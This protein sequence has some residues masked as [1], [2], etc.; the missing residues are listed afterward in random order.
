ML[1]TWAGNR[2]FSAGPVHTP[3]TMAELQEV[4]AA[5]AHIRALGTRHCFNDIA[6]GPG[7]LVSL[8]D[9]DVPVELDEEART[10]TVGGGVRYGEL[11]KVLHERGWALHNLASLGHIS[12]AGA[13]A[14]A[15]H[16]SG[17][18]SQNL[19]AGVVALDLVGPDGELR[20][21]AR[22]DANFAGSVVSLGALGVAARVTLQVEP[23]YDVAQD[24]HV[25]LP[26]DAALANFDE[27]TSSADSVS[28]FTDWAGDDVLQVWRKSRVPAGTTHVS[29]TELFGA[30]PAES[31]RHMIA[32]IDP[33]HTTQQ[34]GVVGPWHERIPHFRLEFTPSNGAEL[35][36]EYLVP[37]PHAV[38][39]IQAMRGLAPVVSPLLQVAEVRTMAG[40][41]LWLSG[42]YGGDTVAL[43][44]TW[45][46]RQ[47]EVEAVLPVIE[48]ALAPFRARPHWGKLFA[49]RDRD[50]ARLYPHWDDFR[51]LVARTDPDGV[52][53]NDYLARHGLVG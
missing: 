51:A 32:G 49:D 16:G 23:T 22:G 21:V 19:S 27:L 33:V 35:Q 7:A 1:T 15:T 37:R 45:Q 29:R 36:S 17:D 28:L 38:D 4:V 52:F 50:L 13:V 42:A 10:A 3:R 6:D 18:R 8:A 44:L 40:D 20:H 26:W 43:H 2:A 9:L 34:L 53:A 30:L 48:E 41:D 24:V 12:V 11:A 14:T 25:D 39:A 31:Q 47:P 5:A 46:L